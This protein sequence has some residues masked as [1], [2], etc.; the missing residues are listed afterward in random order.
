[1]SPTA[2]RK[3]SPGYWILAAAVLLGLYYF[4]GGSSLDLS[5]PPVKEVSYPPLPSDALP[6]PLITAPLEPF[7]HGWAEVSP[8]QA[9]AAEADRKLR[10][11][12]KL[13]KQVSET[14]PSMPPEN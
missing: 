1:M 12:D 2:P 13:Q 6:K 8:M 3:R 10:E 5:Q 9:V 14:P 11:I 4:N 7:Q